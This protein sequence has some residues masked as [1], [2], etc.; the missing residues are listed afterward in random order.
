MEFKPKDSRSQACSSLLHCLHP[1][2]DGDGV[3]ETGERV[4]SKVGE[5][6]G[7]GRQ[8]R[9]QLTLAGERRNGLCTQVLGP[10]GMALGTSREKE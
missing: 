2:S 5:V 4:D 10:R 1:E 9:C 6:G 7:P 3:G 8:G